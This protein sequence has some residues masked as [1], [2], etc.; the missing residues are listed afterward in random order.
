M[1]IL[2]KRILIRVIRTDP[3]YGH[4]HLPE[5]KDTCEA[6][7]LEVGDEIDY[8]SPGDRVIFDRYGGMEFHNDEHPGAILLAEKD[9]LA[10]IEAEGGAQ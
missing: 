4:I 2:G 8:L 3:M 7:V 1:R 5:Q 9:I 10:K 6:A